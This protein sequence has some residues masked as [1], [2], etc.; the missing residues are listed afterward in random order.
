MQIRA[1]PKKASI[2]YE[3]V[4]AQLDPKTMLFCVYGTSSGHCYMV[5]GTMKN[6]RAMALLINRARGFQ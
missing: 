2:E 5:A 4:V 3:R 6:A 1:T